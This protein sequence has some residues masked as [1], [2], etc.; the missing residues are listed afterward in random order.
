[1]ET[2]PSEEARPARRARGSPPP[3]GSSES[4]VE[5]SLVFAGSSEQDVVLAKTFWDSV[6]LQPPLE[7]CLAA[8]RG[9]LFSEA[10][11][12]QGQGS[13]A[14]SRRPSNAGKHDISA[15]PSF[16]KREEER[17]QSA[18]QA[19]K[20]AMKEQYL[21]KA[22]K[23]EEIIALLKKQRE[24]RIAQ[25]ADHSLRPGGSRE[26][27]GLELSPL[28]QLE[29]FPKRQLSPFRN[30]PLWFG[31]VFPHCLLLCPL[32]VMGFQV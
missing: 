31:L 17:K 15:H 14:G 11:P 9:S 30:N 20:N 6:T 10:G 24:E 21:K 1:M 19:E 18:F 12:G 5:E 26:S 25:G 22:K 16:N 13:V 8:R 32:W 4:P 3:P 29:K 28:G 27:E 7:S 23:R 2:R